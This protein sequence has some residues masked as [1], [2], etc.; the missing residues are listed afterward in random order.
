MFAALHLPDLGVL[1]ALR[2]NPACKEKPCAVLELDPELDI[3]AE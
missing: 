1:A 3:V 2:A